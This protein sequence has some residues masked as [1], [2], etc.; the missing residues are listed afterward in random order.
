MKTKKIKVKG[1]AVIF[2]KSVCEDYGVTKGGERLWNVEFEDVEAEYTR[3][4]FIYPSAIF[5]DKK[6]A[7]Q[8]IKNKKVCEIVP[9]EII[10]KI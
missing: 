3:N 6:G 7:R 2:K 10:Y 9:C 4:R 5:E 8:F 1:W